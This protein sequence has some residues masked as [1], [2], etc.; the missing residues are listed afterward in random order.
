M[1]RVLFFAALVAVTFAACKKE[2][3]V[4]E[5]TNEEQ[6]I[7]KNWQLTDHI[8]IIGTL[9]NSIYAAA[10]DACEKDNLYTFA[11][12][13]YYITEEAALKCFVNAPQRDTIYWKMLN[14][15]NL[16]IVDDLDTMTFSVTSVNETTLKLRYPENNIPNELVFTKR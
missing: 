14:D 1:K 9:N 11:N 13:N 16:I 10:Y 12:P 7:N 15:D 8:Q 2:E 5:P 4:P 3:P 6:I